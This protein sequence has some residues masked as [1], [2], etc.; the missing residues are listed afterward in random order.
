MGSIPGSGFLGRLGSK[1]WDC[2]IVKDPYTFVF[3]VSVN[4]SR[5]IR[6]T[7]Q[8]GTFLF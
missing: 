3:E 4:S 6:R 2:Q 7:L 1:N 5:H 8:Q